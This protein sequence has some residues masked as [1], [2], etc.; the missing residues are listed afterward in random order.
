MFALSSSSSAG[1][2]ATNNKILKKKRRQTMG[3][4]MLFGGFFSK[5]DAVFASSSLSSGTRTLLNDGY[6]IELEEKYTS[7][8]SK[9]VSTSTQ[10]IKDESGNIIATIRSEPTGTMGNYGLQSMF[11]NVDEFGEKM[12]GRYK[13]AEED[14]N[15]S[16]ESSKRAA[17]ELEGSGMYAIQLSGNRVVGIV[18]GCKDGENGRKFNQMQT[19][20]A[21]AQA[22]DEGKKEEA[23]R[24]LDSLRL[25]TGKTCGG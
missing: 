25:T 24:I 17:K 10:I 5:T 11:A 9:G 6:S 13:N 22:K 7:E 16:G 20:S 3:E 2:V 23:W 4:M 8:E 19:I 14:E 18:V 15:S 1:C 12:K 21:F